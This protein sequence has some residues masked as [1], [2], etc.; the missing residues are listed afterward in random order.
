MRKLFK[1]SLH[2]GKL[3]EETVR[4]FQAFMNSKKN[5]C[6][7]NY[8]RKYSRS[9]AANKIHALL[10]KDFIPIINLVWANSGNLFYVFIFSFELH[11]KH[12]GVVP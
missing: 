5:S 1:F 6:R 7:G 8:M 2:K 11:F 12:G 4:N 9:K 3:N 10:N